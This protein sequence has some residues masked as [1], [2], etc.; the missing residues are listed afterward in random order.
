MNLPLTRH[1][2]LRRIAIETARMSYPGSMS[3]GKK[4]VVTAGTKARLEEYFHDSFPLDNVWIAAAAIEID[5]ESWHQARV[6]E[7]AKHIIGY[8]ASNNEPESVAAKFLNTF[9]HQ[10]MKYEE[11]RPLFGCLHLPLDARVF[12][13]LRR[14]NSSALRDFKVTFELSPY[15][16]PYATH[17]AIQ[18]ALRSFID[19]LNARPTVGFQVRSRIEL[20]WLWL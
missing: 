13:K 18:A 16:L 14:V 1:D 12:S 5:Y 4:P 20:N 17:T 9:M 3:R 19:E 6:A 2:L 11:A 7:I 15:S 8:V 10:L